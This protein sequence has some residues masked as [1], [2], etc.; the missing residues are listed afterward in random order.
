[1]FFTKLLDILHTKAS[2][3]NT[4][5]FHHPIKTILGHGMDHFGPEK[6]QLTLVMKLSTVGIVL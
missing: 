3:S 6:K 2:Y 5:N 1:M 4:E